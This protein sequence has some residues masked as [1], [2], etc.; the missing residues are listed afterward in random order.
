MG[1]SYR[2]VRIEE[3][4]FF[5]RH[6]K[7]ISIFG[8]LLVFVTFVSKEAKREG[9]K[10]LIDSLNAT[11]SSFLTRS[12]I[13]D[14]RHQVNLLESDVTE[15]SNKL[16]PKERKGID[17]ILHSK[18]FEFSTIELECSDLFERIQHLNSQLPNSS[19]HQEELDDLKD[20][21]DRHE[22][23]IA[24][25][26]QANQENFESEI[27]DYILFFAHLHDVAYNILKEA[28]KEKAIE[29]HRY[30]IWTWTSYILYTVGWLL[31]LAGR[32]FGAE[33]LVS[34]E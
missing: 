30:K 23:D 2:V 1:E 29:E 5:K 13:A 14:I 34:V 25:A 17:K 24:S 32:L 21:M 16:D 27:R 18:E 3:Q 8:A 12:D 9:L 19:L 4:S 33:D 11:E 6:S 26:M 7:S 22:K 15:L 28:E 20:A 31:A 10:E